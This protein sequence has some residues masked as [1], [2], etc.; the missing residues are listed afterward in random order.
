MYKV[1]GGG[2]YTMKLGANYN[3]SAVLNSLTNLFFPGGKHG[4]LSVS[5]LNY[6]L[7]NYVGDPVDETL[8]LFFFYV[9]VF[10]VNMI[11]TKKMR[12]IW[13]LAVWS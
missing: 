5:N 13:H 1:K 12:H 8:Q 2:T 4:K 6:K 7:A 10:D 9:Y 11:E 3:Y